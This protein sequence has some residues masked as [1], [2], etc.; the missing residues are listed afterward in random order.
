VVSK[1]TLLLV[2]VKGELKDLFMKPPTIKHLD[3]S[4]IGDKYGINMV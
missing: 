4:N 1:K 3:E 2:P